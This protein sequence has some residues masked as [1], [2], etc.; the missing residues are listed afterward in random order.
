MAFV[1]ETISEADKKKYDDFNFILPVTRKS[2]PAWKW[3]IDRERDTFLVSLGGQGGEFA[4]IPKFFVL[5]WK[6]KV[7]KIEAFYRFSGDGNMGYDF[8][9]NIAKIVMPEALRHEPEAIICLLKE[10][11]DAYGDIYDRNKI[12]NVYFDIIATP[13]FVPGVQ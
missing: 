10:A 6:N 5:V 9:W 1:N 13:V 4:E 11:I 12:N 2:V 8:T 3:T 7:I